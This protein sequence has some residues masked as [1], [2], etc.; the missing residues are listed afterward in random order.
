M[1]AVVCPPFTI[2]RFLTRSIRSFVD[3]G[4]PDALVHLA[5]KLQES[6]NILLEESFTM[7]VIERSQDG[8]R[9]H[10]EIGLNGTAAGKRGKTSDSLR[11]NRGEINLDLLAFPAGRFETIEASQIPY[12]VGGWEAPDPVRRQG[13]DASADSR[14]RQKHK[15]K[16]LNAGRPLRN[17]PRQLSDRH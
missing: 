7:L 2:W 9:Y 4:G 12:L 13:G 10:E 6:P 1:E 5:S 3:N 16:F 8:T 11:V 14:V 15:R 17:Q